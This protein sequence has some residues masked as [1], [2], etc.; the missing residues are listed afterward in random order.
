MRDNVAFGL[1]M[2]GVPR[3]QTW[4][5][6]QEGLLRIWEDTRKTVIYVTHSID[7]SV[8][9]GD[10]VIVMTA[11][12]GR[13]K[14]EFQVDIPRL[15]S[16]QTAAEAEFVALRGSIWQALEDEVKKTMQTQQ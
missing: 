9:L 14:A 8:L 1:H 7:E 13:K 6:M 2:R 16:I 11:H 5:V 12:P 4:S 3:A 10:R 15:R